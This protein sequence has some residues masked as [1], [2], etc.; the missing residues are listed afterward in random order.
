M[1]KIKAHNWN[2]MTRIY[3]DDKKIWGTRYTNY[4]TI[5]RKLM[6]EKGAEI[7]EQNTTEAE[8]L[9]YIRKYEGS[10]NGNNAQA[11]S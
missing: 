4:W 1:K 7:V 11:K 5:Y 3:S 10:V 2:K 8:V 9:N 6:D